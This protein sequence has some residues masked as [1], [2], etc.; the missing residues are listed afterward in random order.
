VWS[1]ESV[2]QHRRLEAATPLD[3]LEAHVGR[4]VTVIGARERVHVID[5]TL[6]ARCIFRAV[7]RAQRYEAG[8]NRVLRYDDDT[9]VLDYVLRGPDGSTL[10]VDDR[11]TG[12]RP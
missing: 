7:I 12:W 1:R 8:R 3:A 2:R 4:R 10:P 9:W 6:D 5:G 11:P